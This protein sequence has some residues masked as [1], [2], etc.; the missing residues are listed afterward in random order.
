MHVFLLT[1]YKVYD[2]G[3]F[4]GIPKKE[5]DKLIKEGKAVASEDFDTN[6]QE[7]YPDTHPQTIYKTK[8]L[9]AEK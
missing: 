7:H 6:N 5:A 9:K 8:V 1:K 4:I 2:S 3:S